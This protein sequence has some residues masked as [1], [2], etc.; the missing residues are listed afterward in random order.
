MDKKC[1]Y[2]DKRSFDGY[3]LSW[4]ITGL[5]SSTV[6]AARLSRDFITVFKTLSTLCLFSLLFNIT[7]YT[8]THKVK[9]LH[10]ARYH[11]YQH[12]KVHYFIATKSNKQ[13]KRRSNIL[14]EGFADTHTE[15]RKVFYLKFTFLRRRFSFSFY[16]RPLH[17]GGFFTLFH[18]RV[19]RHSHRITIPKHSRFST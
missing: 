7:A 13:E 11:G 3:I 9:L 4:T 16:R 10:A 1:L 14:Y 2:T 6:C 15:L 12:N 5:V 8:Y 19:S 17:S 18:F